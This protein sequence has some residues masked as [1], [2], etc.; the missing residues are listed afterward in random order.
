MWNIFKSLLAYRGFIYGSVK[1]EFQSKYRNSLLG[2]AWTVI[3]PLAMIVVYTVIFSQIMR[4]KLPGVDG[5]FAY[6][7]YLCAGVLTWGLFLEIV[8]RAQ[9][10]FLEHANLLKKLSFPRICLPIIVVANAMV[11]FTIVFGL[12][13]IFLLI[14]GNFPGLAY[15]A[16]F[17]VIGILVMFAIGLGISLG[18]LNVFFR[19]VGQFFGIVIQFWFWL[20]PIVY[21]LSILPEKAR[22]LMSYNPIASL[23][24]AFQDI[25]V[26]GQWPTWQS[27][28]PVTI[29]AV[30]LCG[31]GIRL[32][33]KHVGEMV[34]EL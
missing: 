21:P 33:R 13:S 8:S 31:L 20:T 7:I 4:S 29:I 2:A 26:S 30:T 1:R 19:D 12:F 14:S 15:L 25:L 5:T 18:V 17:P 34:D 16:L 22:S 9:N 6:S 27:L 24:T 11:N 10:T 3:N 28:L 23:M 32:F